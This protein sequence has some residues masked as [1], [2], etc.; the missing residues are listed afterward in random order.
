MGGPGAEGAGR[1][2]MKKS[3]AS[4]P[5]VTVSCSCGAEVVVDTR[6]PNRVSVCFS[7]KAPLRVGP[8][9]R[10]TAP[11]R[12]GGIPPG[13]QEIA[14]R[15]GERLL[16]RAEHLGK[17][18]Q[19]PRCGTQMKLEKVRDPQTLASRVRPSEVPPPKAAAAPGR[20]KKKA[21]GSPK[22]PSEMREVVCRCGERLKVRPEH[23]GR[24]GRCPHCGI[25]MKIEKVGNAGTP[26]YQI[27]VF[28]SE[29][30]IGALQLPASSSASLSAIPSGTVPLRCRCGASL[31]VLPEHQGKQARCPQ[32]GASMRL[33][34]SPDARGGGTSVEAV[35]VNGRQRAPASKIPVASQELLCQCGQPLLV[36]PEHVGR[37]A[38]CPSCGTLM[39][40]E[41][42]VDPLTRAPVL[43][44]VIVGKVD[45]DAWSLDDFS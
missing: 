16:V 14:C 35:P 6:S 11:A 44:A 8:A 33:E 12:Q 42:T 22:D 43:R 32:C 19:C 4:S 30:A 3:K 25:G 15:C 2:D 45:L 28:E 39:R 38:Q 1:R 34:R 36:R 10:E 17:T 40:L 13:A 9:R 20:S 29:A 21:S 37:R 5:L 41:K 26:G 31:L 24:L 27:R 23:L 18:G 7:C